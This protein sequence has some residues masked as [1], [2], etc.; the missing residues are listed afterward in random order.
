MCKIKKGNTSGAHVY[1]LLSILVINIW[2]WE[3]GGY[4]LM[5][6]PYL[7]HRRTKLSKNSPTKMING[8]NKTN[9]HGPKSPIPSTKKYPKAKEPENNAGKGTPPFYPDG[10]TSSILPSKTNNGRNHRLK[11]CSHCRTSLEISG[12]KLQSSCR[13]EQITT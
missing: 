12:H 5:K 13:G 6:Y 2:S 7:Q 4:G 3:K 9:G 10:S 8:M 11:G 1:Y